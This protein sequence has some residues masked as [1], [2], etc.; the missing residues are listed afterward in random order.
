M[1]FYRGRA[2]FLGYLCQIIGLPQGVFAVGGA[3][4]LRKIHHFKGFVRVCS[5][6]YDYSVATLCLYLLKQLS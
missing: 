5:V 1:G 3:I 4:L 2:V 6:F